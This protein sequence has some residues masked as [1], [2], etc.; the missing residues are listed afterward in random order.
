[1]NNK[2]ILFCTHHSERSRE[3]AKCIHDMF[4]NSLV[5]NA[6]NM[7]SDILSRCHKNGCNHQSQNG[8][9]VV[10]FKNPVVDCVFLGFKLKIAF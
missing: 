6:S 3:K 1:M 9:S 4:G 7:F 8:S 2:V 5:I 10:K